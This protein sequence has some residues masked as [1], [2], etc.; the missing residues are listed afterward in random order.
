PAASAIVSL[1]LLPA[2]GVFEVGETRALALVG[3]RANGSTVPIWSAAYSVAPAGA[4]DV[5]A[6]GDVT[7]RAAGPFTVTASLTGSLATPAQASFAA[8]AP[9]SPGERLVRVIDAATRAPLQGVRV[10]LCPDP[11]ASGPCPAVLE[12]Q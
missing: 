12:G 8:Y 7:A 5:T 4:A 10:A 9:A 3:T 1:R 6:S 11:P 2:S